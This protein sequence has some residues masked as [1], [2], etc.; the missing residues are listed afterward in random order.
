[1]KFVRKLSRRVVLLVAV[2]I[3][4][5]SLG[6]GLAFARGTAQPIGTGIVVINTNLA[7]QGS[8]AAGTG[9]VLTSS[10]RVLTNNHVIG[11]ATVAIGKALTIANAIS[12]G[13]A[14]ATVHVGATAFLGIEVEAV[15]GPGALIA[16]VV[17]GGPADS[18]GLAAGDVITAIDGHTVS[19]PSAISALVLTKKPGTTITVS[20][21]D[22]Y[23]TSA[24]ASVTLGSGPA[25]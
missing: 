16:G 19:S 13:K 14:S 18:A 9:I 20:T 6:A 22:Q 7:Y 11:G 10:G 15:A 4:T 2:G 1:M 8:A 3:A 23:G 25:Q 12:S 17:P 24:T 21:V 5:A